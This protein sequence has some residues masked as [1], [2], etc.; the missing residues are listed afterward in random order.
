MDVVICSRELQGIIKSFKDLLCAVV[1]TPKHTNV[2]LSSIIITSTFQN[3]ESFL[4]LN[5]YFKLLLFK[6]VQK[7]KNLFFQKRHFRKFKIN[8]LLNS[9][10]ETQ[11]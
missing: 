8:L 9:C 1:L 10:D 3:T 5:F 2:Q 7:T 4:L 11:L 6:Q